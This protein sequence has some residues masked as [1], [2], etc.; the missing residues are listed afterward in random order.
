VLPRRG[1]GLRKGLWQPGLSTATAYGWFI[2]IKPGVV[3]GWDGFEGEARQ[4]WV[5]PDACV[6]FSRD[7]DRAFA[8]LGS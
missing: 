2:F 7:S 3:A 5:E 8:G 1:S 6:T 4:V